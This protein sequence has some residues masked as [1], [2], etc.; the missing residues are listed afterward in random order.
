MMVASAITI[1]TPSASIDGEAVAARLSQAAVIKVSN[2]ICVRLSVGHCLCAAAVCR[3][4]VALEVRAVI[5]RVL[6]LGFDR[7]LLL[8]LAYPL[9][10]RNGL[11]QLVGLLLLSNLQQS[12]L[13][14]PLHGGEIRLLQRIGR[15]T[16]GL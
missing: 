6:K 13:V 4:N 9:H 3:R 1:R 8:L 12:G 11:L 15:L 5:G 10:Q 14:D 16:F 2:P 7:I